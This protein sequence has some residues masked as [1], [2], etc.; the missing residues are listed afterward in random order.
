MQRCYIYQETTKS[1]VCCCDHLRAVAFWETALDEIVPCG[2]TSVQKRTSV[3]VCLLVHCNI[4]IIFFRPS[5]VCRFDFAYGCQAGVLWRTPHYIGA[6]SQ[7]I[8]Q[9]ATYLGVTEPQRNVR[10][11][12]VI[13][14]YIVACL[15]MQLH[16]A[17]T[18]EDVGMG[19]LL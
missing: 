2:P 19:G 12:T 4:I 3:L 7:I 6:C 1:S 16:T 14:I 8:V 10:N 9:L 11:E 15:V 13:Y 18:F 5:Y 17:G